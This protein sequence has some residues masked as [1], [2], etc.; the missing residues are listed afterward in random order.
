M[1]LYINDVPLE[2]EWI[3][4][5]WAANKSP[6]YLETI[7]IPEEAGTNPIS[8]SVEVREK[9]TQEIPAW[10]AKRNRAFIKSLEFIPTKNNY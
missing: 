4:W 3:Q 7:I 2:K 10:L 8:I 1:Q 6:I 5:K 9:T